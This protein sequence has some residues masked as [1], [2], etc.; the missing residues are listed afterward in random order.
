MYQG[1]D[2]CIGNV[3]GYW[4]LRIC[5]SLD[6]PVS[7]RKWRSIACLGPFTTPSTNSHSK[8]FSFHFFRTHFFQSYA[9]ALSRDTN[10]RTR[11]PK[12]FLFIFFSSPP[13]KVPRKPAR[14]RIPKHFFWPFPYFLGTLSL[15]TAPA[16][17]PEYLQK[18]SKVE[19][20]KSAPLYM[21]PVKSVVTDVQSCIC[22]L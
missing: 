4:L 6:A 2:F 10:T 19:F 14:T 9:W 8:V 13:P 12:Q 21:Y 15:H 1:T 17:I 18:F 22:T 20:Q 3:L 16:R 11:I 5:V 7:R